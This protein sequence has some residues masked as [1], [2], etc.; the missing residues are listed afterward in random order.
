MIPPILIC[1]S[2][3]APQRWSSWEDSVRLKYLGI[4]Q[5][6]MGE[7]EYTFHGGTS[8][9]TGEQ[10]IMTVPSIMSVKSHFTRKYKVPALTAENLFRRDRF[11]C[12]YCGRFC[13]GDQAT[14][15]HIVPQSKN[16]AHTWNNTVLA[17]R[18]CN[19]RKGNK[20]LEDTDMELLWIPYTPDF[21]EVLILRNR[22]ILADQAEFLVGF[23][24]NEKSRVKDLLRTVH[25]YD[26]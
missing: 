19:H 22:S 4:V 8:R 26:F 15:D 16:G 10:S 6:E 12:S 25:G 18:R 2:T 3:G 7:N 13:K 20:M 23:V 17:C 9:M 1:D 24:K 11:H 14:I 5:W 21:N